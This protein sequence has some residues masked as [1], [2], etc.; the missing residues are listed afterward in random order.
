MFKVGELRRSPEIS[1]SENT[2]DLL[3][4][5]SCP[6]QTQRLAAMREPDLPKKQLQEPGGGFPAA[7]TSAREICWDPTG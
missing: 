6:L 5:C 3:P 4:V 1:T 7:K 2:T